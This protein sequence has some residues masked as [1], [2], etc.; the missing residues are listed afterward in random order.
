MRWSGALGQTSG[1]GDLDGSQCAGN[2]AIVEALLKAGAD[3]NERLP[4]GEIALMMASRTG[5]TTAMKVLLDRG[6]EVNAK[7]KLRGTTA[8]MW[9]ADQ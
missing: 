8:L 9:A 5:N 7:E 4:H 2:A 1:A 3:P 6:A